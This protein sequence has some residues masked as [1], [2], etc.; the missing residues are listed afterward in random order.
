MLY[1][2]NHVNIFHYDQ[3]PNDQMSIMCL[4]YGNAASSWIRNWIFIIIWIEFEPI[5]I[6]LNMGSIGVHMGCILFT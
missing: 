5:S 1:E 6:S 2:L 3:R 4:M